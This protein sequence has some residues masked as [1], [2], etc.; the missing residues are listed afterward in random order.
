MSCGR[1]IRLVST[2]G[3]V[4]RVVKGPELKPSPLLVCLLEVG[5]GGQRGCSSNSKCQVRHRDHSSPAPGRG[6]RAW[7]PG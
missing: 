2:L 6:G 4:L 5:C 3:L 7:L 1:R